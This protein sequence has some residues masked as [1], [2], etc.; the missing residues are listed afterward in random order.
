MLAAILAEVLGV[1][2]VPVES[3]FFDDLRADSLL[4]AHFCAR[5]RKCSDLPPASMRDIYAHPTIRRLAGALATAR[6]AAPAAPGPAPVAAPE[7]PMPVSTREYLACAALQILFY[8]VSAY[9]SVIGAVAGYR[10]IVA[11][12]AGVESYVR[13]VLF[14]AVAL[15][16]VSTVPIAAK[17][18]LIGR[19]KPQQIRAWSLAYFRFWVVKNLIRSSPG[20]HLFLGTPLYALYLRALGAKIGP[21]VVIHSRT[22][23]VCTDLLTIGADTVIRAEAMFECYRVQAGRIEV[24][25]VTIGK[26]AFVGERSVL[27]TDTS[28][29]D[30][31]QLGHGSALHS[32]QAVPAGERWNGSPAQRAEVD[33]KR[34]APARCGTLRR[35]A[36]ASCFL[37]G[38]LLLWVPLA[39]GAVVLLYAAVSAILEA[40]DPGVIG[41]AGELTARGL[42]VEALVFSAVFFFGGVLVSLV[43]VGVVCRVLGL[44]V[45]PDTVYPLYGLRYA[46]HWVIGG[47]SKNRLLLN[48]FGDSS[49]VTGYLRWV[50]FHLSPLVQTGSNF[51]TVVKAA[52]PHLTAIGTGS[53]VADGLNVLNDEFSSTSFR[54]SRAAVG[55]RS[56]LGNHVTYPAGARM[57]D[58]C[59]LATKA[60]VPLDGHI[61]EGVGLLGSPPFEIPRSV[62]RDVRFDHLR[63]GEALRAGLAAKNRF[64]LRT[65]GLF[66]V[67]RWLCVFLIVVI[68]VA[69]FRVCDGMFA[70]TVT[71]ALF[72]ASWFVAAVYFALSER[73]VAA[74]GPPPPRLC[75]MYDPAFWQVERVWKMHPLSVLQV[76]DGTPFKSVVYRLMGARI[77]KRVLDDGAHISDP[78][79]TTIGDDCVFGHLS[80]VQCHS[81]EDG[82]YKSGPIT[83]GAGCVLGSAAM[84]HYGVTMG[85]GS[86]LAA[87][88]FLMKGEDVPPHAR[89][90][91]NPARE[92]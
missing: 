31:A 47:I 26:D 21:R 53:M 68:D 52:S 90:G 6:T 77:G 67:Q 72:A 58:N 45:R 25:P 51:G 66:L 44:L 57:G 85:D 49:W 38:S 15:V 35:A 18:L 42:L 40:L 5:V 7:R 43:A 75:S 61:R 86:E 54:V 82:T 60:M 76:F 80:S 12:G 16:V 36:Y 64:N 11:D 8:F 92:I 88:S 2:R 81:Q 39:E 13:L 32:G 27:D 87:D 84:V 28:I 79:M 50:G 46:A 10:W 83:L 24:G 48:L 29:G 22:I 55:P 74:L 19:W 62:E 14:G 9:L 65:I 1:D 78:H 23:P 69:A 63:T 70:H 59:L 91:G 73:L 89:W 34:V 37:L 71:A 41:S 20:A 17:W 33:Y 3:H 4:M 56:F 30:G